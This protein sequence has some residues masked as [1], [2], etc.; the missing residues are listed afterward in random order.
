MAED[1]MKLLTWLAKVLPDISEETQQAATYWILV[2][3]VAQ[4]ILVT[5]L[6]FLPR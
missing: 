2:L 5:A 1:L 6:A 4:A 3:M